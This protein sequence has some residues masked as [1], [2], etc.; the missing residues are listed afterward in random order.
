MQLS[1]SGAPKRMEGMKSRKT[2]ETEREIMKAREQTRGNWRRKAEKER[3]RAKSVLGWRPGRRPVIAPRIIPR[4]EK[5][6]ISRS[7]KKFISGEEKLEGI[8]VL[9]SSL[10]NP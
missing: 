1:G 10:L 5:A 9:Y 8:T 7:M 4:K 2:L 6:R 3:T